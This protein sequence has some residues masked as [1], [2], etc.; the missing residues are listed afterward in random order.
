MRQMSAAQS[1]EKTSPMARVWFSVSPRWPSSSS[2]P[3]NTTPSWAG[4][5]D[6]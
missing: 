4:G 2:T 5:P 6:W 1:A 3:D